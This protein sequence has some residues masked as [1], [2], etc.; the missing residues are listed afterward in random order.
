MSAVARDP[1][2][3][4]SLCRTVSTASASAGRL[5]RGGRGGVPPRPG[6]IGCASPAWWRR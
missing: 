5:C 3:D 6:V 4:S 1:R 2:L